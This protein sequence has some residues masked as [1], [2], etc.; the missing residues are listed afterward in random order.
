MA[1]KESGNENSSQRS[2]TISDGKC[3]ERW[4]LCR[5]ENSSQHRGPDKQSTGKRQQHS[6][7]MLAVE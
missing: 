7:L 1:D 3:D 6:I 2:D 4:S 5:E